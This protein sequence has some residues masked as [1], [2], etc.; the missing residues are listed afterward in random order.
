M[1]ENGTELQN[2]R[3]KLCTRPL[4]IWFL[5]ILFKSVRLVLKNSVIYGWYKIWLG[6]KKTQKPR[7]QK[8]VYIL[9]SN[10]LK[11]LVTIM[12]INLLTSKRPIFY[13]WCI[14]KKKFEWTL[15]IVCKHFRSLIKTPFERRKVCLR[16]FEFAIMYSL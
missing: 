10:L 16:P 1:K 11:K 5:Y 15:K 3:G 6:D 7:K 12:N 2:L 8:K 13:L 9:G 14:F 4:L